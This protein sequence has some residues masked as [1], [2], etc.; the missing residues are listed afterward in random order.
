MAGQLRILVIRTSEK[1]KIT[2]I[3]VR[4]S[5]FIRIPQKGHQGAAVKEHDAI[6]C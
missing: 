4:M 3:V 5:Q 6:S 2:R 1:K